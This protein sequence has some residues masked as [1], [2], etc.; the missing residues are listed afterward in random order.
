MFPFS[1]PEN[2]FSLIMIDACGGGDLD[3]P[4]CDSGFT[5]FQ[6]A[7]PLRSNL[8]KVHLLG[9]TVSTALDWEFVSLN[10]TSCPVAEQVVVLD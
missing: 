3:F 10:S 1:Y 9:G 6:F 7:W 5:E 8:F 4:P 2:L